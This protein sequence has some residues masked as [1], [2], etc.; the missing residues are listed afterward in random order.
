MGTGKDKLEWTLTAD[1]K[2][3]VKSLYRKLIEVDYDFPQ[4]FLWKVKVPAKIKVSF[5]L[6]ARKSILT[7]DS[8]LR[9]GWKGSK[10][11]VFVVKMKQL[12]IYFSAVLLLL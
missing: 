12:T 6:M 7:T 4:K 8:L 5:W 3:T 11:S 1:K 9:R 10:L 2:F